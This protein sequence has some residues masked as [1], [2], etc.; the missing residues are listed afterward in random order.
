MIQLLRRR[1]R[2]RPGALFCI[3][4]T[5]VGNQAFADWRCDPKIGGCHAVY[6]VSDR[7]H[8]GIVLSK[9]DVPITSLPEIRDFLGFQMIEISWGDRDYF[10][11]PEPGIYAA[12]RA[13]FWSN[14]SVLHV[15]G[16]NGPVAAFYPSASVDELR[17]T[18]AAFARLLLFV[19]R[20]FLRPEPARPAPP[21]PGLVADSRFYHA[22]SKFSLARTC[23]TWVA[24][25]LSYAG[26][27]IEAPAIITGNQLQAEVGRFSASP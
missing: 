16:F 26:L 4:A 5:L 2:I 7:W 19:T 22:A 9:G 15:V 11:D 12:L 23:N 3:L 10:P 24:E 1:T 6:V 20:E 18:E 13:A 21:R 8:A 14:G 25:A 27:P 17:I